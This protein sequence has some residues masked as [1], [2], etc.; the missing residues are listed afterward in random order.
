MHLCISHLTCQGTIAAGPAILAASPAGE[1]ASV[2]H[3]PS[4]SVATASGAGAP[5]LRLVVR[6]ALADRALIGPA[7]L[8]VVAATMLLATSVV[9]ADVARRDGVVRALAAAPPAE[10]V[11]RVRAPLDVATADADLERVGSLLAGS[12]GGT[13]ADVVASVRSTSYALPGTA[14]VP[15]LTRFESVEAIAAHADLVDGRW[16]E[17]DRRPIEAVVTEQAADP[18]GVGAGS[19]ITLTRRTDG[20]VHEV[21]V[22]GVVRLAASA[23]P[24]VSDEPLLRDGREQ[25]ATFL[26][27]GPLLVPRADVLALATG[28][29]VDARWAAAPEPSALDPEELRPVANRVGRLEGVV[30]ADLGTNAPRVSS[31]LP[32]HLRAVAGSL[33]AGS[34]GVLLLDAQLAILAGYGLMLIAVLLLEERRAETA[35]FRSRGADGVALVAWAL[36]EAVIL[37]L[38]AAVVGLVLAFVVVAL[39]PRVGVLGSPDSPLPRLDA[40]SVGVTLVAGGAALVGFLLPTLASLGPLAAVR[41]AV[42]R[43]VP[44]GA[45]QRTG[46]DLALVALAAIAL[47]QLRVYGTPITRDLRGTLGVDPLL[48]AAPALALLAGAV[49]TLRIVPLLAVGAERLV[50]GARGLLLPLAARQLARRP[51]R[52]SRT[53]LLLVMAGAIN[54]FAA[55]Y[56]GTWSTSQA[57][58]VDH[59]VG[60]DL[61]IDM[62]GADLPTWA[63]DALLAGTPGVAAHTPMLREDVDLGA[64]GRGTLVAL[65]PEAAGVVRLRADRADGAVEDRF[66]GLAAARPALGGVALPGAPTAIRVSLRTALEGWVTEEHPVALDP[67]FPGASAAVV[68]R[69]A[70]GWVLRAAS[71]RAALDATPKDLTIPLHATLADGTTVVPRA[72]LELLAVEVVLELPDATAAV[73]SADVVEVATAEASTGAAVGSA[74]AWTALPGVPGDGWTL[75]RQAPNEDPVSTGPAASGRLTF[76]EP[77]A[78]VGPAPARLALR[79]PGLGQVTPLAVPALV[80]PQL[81]SALGAAEG[82][83]VTVSERFGDPR[84]IVVTGTLRGF[85]TI[86]AGRPFAV[87]DLRTLALSDY[88][89]HGRSPDPRTWLASTA[90]GGDPRATATAIAA[91]PVPATVTVRDEVLE[92]RL[93]DPVTAAIL[94]TLALGSIAAMAFAAIGFVVTASVGIRERL[95]DL[96]V[97]AA[98]GVGRA[99]LL[100]WLAVEQAVLLALG[101]ALGVALGMIVAWVALPSLTLGPAGVAVDPPALVVVA[102]EPVVAVVAV[103]LALLLAA[104]S[105]L[106]RA[107]RRSDVPSVLRAGEA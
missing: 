12:L 61:A 93:D 102:W 79:A 103:G 11:V 85:P 39:G 29:T 28:R 80:D 100:A 60:A 13:G 77:S 18:L 81:A 15:D 37:V 19:A 106:A 26:T 53:A 42:G 46:I 38:S 86:A 10:L 96:A 16:P 92:V 72:P 17:A 69:D 62:S 59:E 71:E 33:L 52:Q 44:R 82:D 40:G 7:W 54:V 84:S 43:Q 21:L 27:L 20:S 67:A 107:V 105:L 94:T 88:L 23:G 87:L 31:A 36:A 3:D 55:A 2:D 41:R 56:A 51:A 34:A 25:G 95:P 76:T 65:G 83:T 9:H 24:L 73:G 70:A 89:A 32:E 91:G 68:V 5:T 45:A 8:L 1:S 78:I 35:L 48:V 75:T 30:S 47:W 22:T 58:Q 14:E 66:A 64:A 50:A 4:V 97:L 99:R 104:T 63:V 90:E 6:R 101:L 74:T 98:L 57:D 49:V